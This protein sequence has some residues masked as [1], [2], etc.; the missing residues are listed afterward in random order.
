MKI[1]K[2][3]F[4][5][6][7]KNFL[8]LAFAQLMLFFSSLFFLIFVKYKLTYYLNKIREF[9]PQLQQVL[10]TVDVN[11]P[12]TIDSSLT[13]IEALNS[14]T[15]EATLF[16]Y[17]IVPLVLLTIWVLF[18]ALF[19]SKIKEHKIQSV[20]LYLTRLAM[21][22]VFILVLFSQLAVPKE[23]TD[24]FN[25]FD[26]SILRILFSAFIG[27]YLLTMYYAVLNNQSLKDALKQT[28]NIAIK[29]F[30]KFLPIYFPLFIISS[31]ILWL[32]AIILTQEYTQTTAYFSTTSLIIITIVLLTVSKFYKILLQNIVNK[33]CG[34]K[35]SNLSKH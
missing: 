28:F 4:K 20:K 15:N 35:D 3:T 12:A 10:N 34:S 18:Q 24:F 21:P 11:N 25:T 8:T 22:S 29:K 7:K 32:L 33:E 9:E 6:Y 23:I 17:I 27:L 13:V 2:P 26:D 30:Y 19:W 1:L 31:T 16:A 14:V 5:S